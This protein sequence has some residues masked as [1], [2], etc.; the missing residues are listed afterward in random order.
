[1]EL[2]R[3][4][5]PSP[6]GKNVLYTVGGETGINL[7]ELWAYYNLCSSLNAAKGL[8]RSGGATFTT[9]GTMT[10]GTPYLQVES[11]PT[12]CTSDDG[13]YFKQPVVIS[14]QMIL[15]LES[16]AVGSAKRLHLV[17]DPVI[18]LWNPLDVPVVVPQSSFFTV[19]FWQIPYD[20]LINRSKTGFKTYP[21]AAT[22]SNA[23]NTSDGDSNSKMP[24]RLRFFSS[25]LFY[26]QPKH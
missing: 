14:Y 4:T 1:M 15:S 16:R 10:S 6:T 2:E 3:R 17:A 24:Q 11:S 8:K 12:A 20:L 5:A 25:D 18:T 13:F 21:L 9:G 26:R 22:L 7:Q 19:K 23:S